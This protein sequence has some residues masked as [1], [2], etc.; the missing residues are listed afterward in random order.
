MQAH[1]LDE[2]K[3]EQTL[4]YR[5]LTTKKFV[6]GYDIIMPLCYWLSRGY[7]KDLDDLC[8]SG[9]VTEGPAAAE[10]IH[11]PPRTLGA[12]LAQNAQ[13]YTDGSVRLEML[14]HFPWSHISHDSLDGWTT[15]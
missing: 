11:A 7:R 6:L 5:L 14:M 3:Y 15:R 2:S 8:A 12:V 1:S 4:E 10:P 9:D 13:I